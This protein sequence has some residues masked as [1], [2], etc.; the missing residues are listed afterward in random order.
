M[1]YVVKRDNQYIKVKNNRPIT[2][3][4]LSKAT[5]Y[6]TEA[7]AEGFINNHIR[8]DDRDLY[9]VTKYSAEK[10]P[11]ISSLI[12][13]PKAVTKSV[14]P[15]TT[16]T[17]TDIVCDL[18]DIKFQIVNRFSHHKSELQKEIER[19]DNIILDIRHFSRDSN[20]R[21]NACQA[22]KTF[23]KQQEVERQR[24]IAKKELT[25]IYEVEEFI[26]NA[27]NKAKSFDFDDYKPREIINM[28]EFLE[29]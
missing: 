4:E 11:P 19:C 12:S 20:T 3:T 8:P 6:N 14:Q 21:L 17:K 22:A 10:L 5:K 26:N 15:V 9:T 25:R 28:V 1:A 24:A 7:Q 2:V 16:V 18:Q 29:L 13:K 27:I 23:Y